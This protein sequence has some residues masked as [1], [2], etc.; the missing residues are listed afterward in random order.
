[1]DNVTHN[2]LSHDNLP[3]CVVSVDRFVV[4]EIVMCEIVTE[5]P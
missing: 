2:D 1:M 4:R 3:T 5:P